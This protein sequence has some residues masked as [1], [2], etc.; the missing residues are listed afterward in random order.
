VGGD[1]KR[2]YRKEQEDDE[3]VNMKMRWAGTER[4]LIEKN[5]MMIGM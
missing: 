1:K 5:R 2:S 3:D 4:D